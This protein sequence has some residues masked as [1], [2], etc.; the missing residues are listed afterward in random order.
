M[1]FVIPPKSSPTGHFF[2]PC[3]R[4]R[5]RRGPSF[6]GSSKVF[7]SQVAG[8]WYSMVVNDQRKFRGRNFRVTDF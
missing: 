7:S 3:R 5:S 2:S 1:L 6:G 4:K 8:N